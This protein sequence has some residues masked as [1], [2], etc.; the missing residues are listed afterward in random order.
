MATPKQPSPIV[1]LKSIRTCAEN[2][3][4]L[5]EETYDL[6]FREPPSSRYFL[7]M[8][9]QEEFAKAFV[10]FLIKEDI[11]PFS[12]LVLRAINGHACKQLVGM[13][14]DYII[15]HWENIE[16]LHTAIRNDHELGD[17]LPHGVGSAMDL[18]RYEKIGRWES[19]TWVWADEPGYE[20]SALW[21]AKG[22]KDRRRQDALYVRIGRDGQVCSTP[23]TINEDE[24][25]DNFE[26]ACRYQLF[27]DSVLDGKVASYRYDKAIVA[28]KLLFYPQQRL[29]D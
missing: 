24:T 11:V 25:R 26:R 2:G 6:E 22:K 27:V 18:L 28:L 3:K 1:L 14:M 23:E 17:R 7:I 29:V 8:T 16:E 21:I 4:R 20:S 5:L 13:I 15:M 9:A 19:S 10:L 12:S